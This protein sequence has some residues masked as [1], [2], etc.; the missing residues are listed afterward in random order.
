MET[1]YFSSFKGV[2]IEHEDGRCF[3]KA[4]DIAEIVSPNLTP[5]VSA[6]LKKHVAPEFT[7]KFKIGK[8]NALAWFV[9]IRGIS[10]FM[11]AFKGEKRDKFVNWLISYVVPTYIKK[12][13]VQV[14][15]KTVEDLVV[16]QVSDVP[17]EQAVTEFVFPATN[18]PMRTVKIQGEPWFVA[19]DVCD[20]LE[21]G[22]VS[23]A[24]SGL[25]DDEKM[26]ITNP[27]SHSG[28]RGGAQFITLINESGFYSLVGKSRKPQAKVFKRWVN[29]EVLPA[30]RKDGGYIMGEEKVLTGEMSEDELIH[31]ALQVSVSKIERLKKE[32]LALKDQA[33]QLE[34]QTIELEKKADVYSAKANEFDHFVSTGGLMIP[35]VAAKLIGAPV[36][37]LTEFMREEDWIW[38]NIKNGI[39]PKQWV[40]DRGWMETK[41]TKAPFGMMQHVQ[42]CLTTLGLDKL[43]KLWNEKN[44]RSGMIWF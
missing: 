1:A 43:F 38:K 7:K 22:N 31:K 13:V 35:S 8:M 18:S 14:E 21:L 41:V 16:E 20:V 17:Q 37:K 10:D 2:V 33:Q 26:T 30:I 32:N 34:L 11:K 27:D 44:G 42:G 28:K 25:D 12:E 5:V 36:R 24:L 15:E 3:L 23:Q 6:L 40:I 19:K 29:H 4:S 39:I 9:D